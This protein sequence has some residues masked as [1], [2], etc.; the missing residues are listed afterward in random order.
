MEGVF[1][2]GKVFGVTPGF[3]SKVLKRTQGAR[4]LLKTVRRR[5]RMRGHC[6]GELV[7]RRPHPETFP[8][9]ADYLHVCASREEGL[10]M[11]EKRKKASRPHGPAE[12]RN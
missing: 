6:D 4:M 7:R 1:L 12:G 9:K 2:N 11:E 8:A 10:A 5:E 3:A